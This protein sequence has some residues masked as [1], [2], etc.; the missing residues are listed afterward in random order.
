MPAREGDLPVVLLDGKADKQLLT[1][2]LLVVVARL[3]RR[4]RLGLELPPFLHPWICGLLL[5]L[6]GA[7]AR[8]CA[9]RT[10]DQP[11]LG[12][13]VLNV[14]GSRRLRRCAPL[15]AC[16]KRRSGEDGE[17]RRLGFV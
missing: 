13:A 14:V 1:G 10:A 9:A 7:A 15:Q 4:L 17:K 12:W 2:E 5:H 16:E 6:L 11:H 3:E 8:E